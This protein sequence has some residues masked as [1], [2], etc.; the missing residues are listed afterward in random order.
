MW[1]TLRNLLFSKMSCSVPKVRK[2]N[3]SDVNHPAD[4]A[5]HFNNYFCGIGKSLADQINESCDKDP[6][7]F[8]RNRIP[9]SIFIVPT[10]PQEIERIISPLHNSSSGPEGFSSFFIK[11]ASSV[12]ASPTSFIFNFRTENGIFPES[13]KISKVILIYKSGAKSE[14]NNYRPISLLPVLSKVFE[15]VLHKKITSPLSKN[16]LFF[17][18]LNMVSGR[19]ILQNMRF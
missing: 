7:H 17:H 8:L 12:L 9:E 15:K 19:I 1:K 10:Y 2:I 18:L 4:I 6:S 5:N 3:N 13:L 16:I 11:T 14:V